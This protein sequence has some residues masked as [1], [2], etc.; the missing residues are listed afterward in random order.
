MIDNTQE[1]I[2]CAAIKRLNR[3]TSN[4]SNELQFIEIGLR[5]NDIYQ[6]FPDE[7]S[8]KPCDQGFLTS[9]GRFV[10]RLE[11]SDIAFD[12]G[13]ITKIK[14]ILYSEDLY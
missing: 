6:R 1:Y 11:A 13:Q 7:V 4:L 8:K 14:D 5:H 9:K 2:I 10:D 12:C 3:K